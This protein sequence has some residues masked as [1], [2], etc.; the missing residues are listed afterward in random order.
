MTPLSWR[1]SSGRSPRFAKPMI[2]RHPSCS[3][4]A[5]REPAG[6]PGPDDHRSEPRRCGRSSSPN[7][8]KSHRPMRS[9]R[10]KAKDQ[11]G[12]L[13]WCCATIRPGRPSSRLAAAVDGSASK[14][15][16]RPLP[17][18]ARRCQAHIRRARIERQSNASGAGG[19]DAREGSAGEMLRAPLYPVTP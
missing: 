12:F 6:Q 17:R 1:R 19:L 9:R 13:A 11:Y 16:A 14:R 5:R 2:A 10:R 7:R 3:G 18:L 8:A 4:A 15:R